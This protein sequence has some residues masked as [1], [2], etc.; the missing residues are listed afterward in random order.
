MNKTSI[1]NNIIRISIS[2][3][4]I[5]IINSKDKELNKEEFYPYV[6]IKI[7]FN[8]HVSRT[9]E[10]LV[11]SGSDRNLFPAFLGE[12]IGISFRGDAGK[13]IHG[14]G[15]SQIR[16]Y[17]KKVKLYLNKLSFDVE[18]D[19]SFQQNIPL[20]GRNGFFNLFSPS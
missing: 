15:N 5:P 6:P 1:Q 12:V 16:A 11:D 4:P 13:T 2:Y 20:L 8:Q 17:P 9:F 14:I 7:S 19:F 3:L 10:A 18:I